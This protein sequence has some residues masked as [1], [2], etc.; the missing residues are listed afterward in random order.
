M[1]CDHTNVTQDSIAGAFQIHAVINVN[2]TLLS[3]SRSS[4]RGA[5]QLMNTERNREK[6]RGVT[7]IREESHASRSRHAHAHA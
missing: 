5:V 7:Y 2:S 1:K 4:S 6:E 3:L